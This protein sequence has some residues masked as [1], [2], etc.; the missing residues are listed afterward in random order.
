MVEIM[1]SILQGQRASICR[2][3]ICI[4]LHYVTLGILPSLALTV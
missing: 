2:G 1:D 4:T 3:L